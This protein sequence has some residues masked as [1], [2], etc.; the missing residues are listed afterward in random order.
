[1][2]EHRLDEITIERPRCGL[3]ISA[4]K[5]T[6]YKKSLKKIT[7]EAS[8]DGLLQPYLL[9]AWKRSK[10]FSDNLAPLESWLKSKVGQPWNDIY[11]ELC[12]ILNRDTVTG[13][14]V[15]SHLW[16]FVARDVAIIDGLPYRKTNPDR[17]LCSYR[18]W[19]KFFIH[20]DT[21]FLCQVPRER[22][23][24]QKSHACECDRLKIDNYHEYQKLDNLWYLVTFEDIPQNRIVTDAILKLP[25][26]RQYWRTLYAVRKK[27]CNKK[28]IK[29]INQQLAKQ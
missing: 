9:K 5:L 29:F 18:W 25:V 1:M 21:G 12:K 20:P 19:N 4:K 14:H 6:G 26:N 13:R 15:F 2:S 16:D 8:E 11:S 23:Q 24:S 27:Q 7:D 10:Y 28:E 17:P 22:K 3:K